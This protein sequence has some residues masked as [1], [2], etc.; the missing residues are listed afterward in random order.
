MQVLKDEVRN[1]IIEAAK[2]EFYEKGFEKAAIRTM[3]KKA[4]TTIGNFYNYFESKNEVFSIVVKPIIEK[5][6]YL[7]NYHHKS[8]VEANN[9]SKEIIFSELNTFFPLG[10]EEIFNKNFVI[11]ME[12]NKGSEFDGFNFKFLSMLEGHFLS[13]L[14]ENQHNVLLSKMIAAAFLQGILTMIKCNPCEKLSK[15]ALY[16]YLFIFIKGIEL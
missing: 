7:I 11:L 2:D 10:F 12:G 8:N 16:S 4:G 3:A 1:S 14:E 9:L 15:E 13:H 5:V 6:D